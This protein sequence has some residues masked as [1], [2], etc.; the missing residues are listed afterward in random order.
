MNLRQRDVEV[1]ADGPDDSGASVVYP[2]C[3][4]NS[5]ELRLDS[6]ANWTSSLHTSVA[7]VYAYTNSKAI[8]YEAAFS[9]SSI[10]RTSI[11]AAAGIHP[12]GW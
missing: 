1:E 2:L 7:M 10:F 3:R 9:K 8:R 12:L 4:R 5:P 11:T 6:P